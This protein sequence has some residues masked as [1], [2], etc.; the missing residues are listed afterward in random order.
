[1]VV[2]AL[3]LLGAS[4]ANAQE[5]PAPAPSDPVDS[6]PGDAPGNADIANMALVCVATYDLVISKQPS[7]P[8]A[9]AMSDARDLARSIYIEV[10]DSDEATA[11]DDIART[12][13]ALADAVAG[14][15]GNLDEYHSTCGSLL[16]EDE[17]EGGGETGATIS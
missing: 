15:K 10:T 6:A 12:D 8:Q 11:D 5:M 7:G 9:D 1:M 16:M 14:G 2:S 17:P 4:V 3:A 13:K